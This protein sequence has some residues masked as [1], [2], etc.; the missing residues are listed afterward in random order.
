MEIRDLDAISLEK[1][2]RELLGNERNVQVDFLL[3]LAEFDRRHVHEGLGYS[4]IWNYCRRKLFLAEATTF[5]RIHAAVLLRKYPFVEG[6]LRD[7]RLCPARLVKLEKVLTPENARRLFDR[8]SGASRR[9]LD[10]LVAELNPRPDPAP[11]LRKLPRRRDARVDSSRRDL[12]NSVNSP[13][14][15]RAGLEP[16]PSIPASGPGI[17]S[18]V[19]AGA[20]GGSDRVQDGSIDHFQNAQTVVRAEISEVVPIAPERFVLRIAVGKEFVDDLELG[21]DLHSHVI[22]AHDYAGIIALA[23][24]EFVDRHAKRKGAMAVRAKKSASVPDYSAGDAGGAGSA[25]TQNE[26]S[27]VEVASTEVTSGSTTAVRGATTTES[28]QG[29]ARMNEFVKAAADSTFRITMATKRIVW[30]RDGGCCVWPLAGGGGCGSRRRIQFDHILAGARGGSAEPENIRLLCAEHNAQHA[31]EDFGRA[32]VESRKN[33]ARARVRDRVEYATTTRDDDGPPIVREAV[34]AYRLA[35]D[36]HRGSPEAVRS[37][38]AARAAGA[39][40]RRCSRFLDS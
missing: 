10:E 25:L 7:G 29:G 39:R 18:A 33:A 22:S 37:R 12:E 38:V 8:A 34:A 16:S 4:N 13:S 40:R 23:L 32:F 11:L 6:Y 2:L 20:S 26:T 31:R 36:F 35:G 3:H 14:V 21:L 30:E 19:V 9:E 28:S 15:E 5:R 1:R 27:T 17:D 24:R